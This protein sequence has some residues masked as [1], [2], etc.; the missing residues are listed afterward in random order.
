MK[1]EEI[2]NKILLNDLSVE[3]EQNHVKTCPECKAFNKDLGIMM[4]QNENI[5]VPSVLDEKVLSFAKQNRP[6]GSKNIIPFILF[7]VA[8]L[9]VIALTMNSLSKVTINKGTVA[10]VDGVEIMNQDIKAVKTVESLEVTRQ[11]EI[12]ESL[13]DDNQIDADLLAL[14][15]ELFVLSAEL[16]SE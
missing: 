6:Q 14:E 4:T 13:W 3:S 1:C 5:E 16:Y 11:D 8:A 12:I 15:G 7:A 2:Q 10:T 9:V